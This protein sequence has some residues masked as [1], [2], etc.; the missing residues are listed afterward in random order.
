MAG[1]R[2]LLDDLSTERAQ[3]PLQPPSTVQAPPSFPQKMPMTVPYSSDVCT[4]VYRCC[5]A[6]I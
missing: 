4:Y 2:N 1:A 3:P 5:L 6:L